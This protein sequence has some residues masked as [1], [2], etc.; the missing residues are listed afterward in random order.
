M[1]IG[2]GGGDRLAWLAAAGRNSRRCGRCCSLVVLSHYSQQLREKALTMKSSIRGAILGTAGVA[3][4]G[5]AGCSD[6]NVK[7]AGEDFTNTQAAPPAADAKA[8]TK[9]DL[10]KR[11]SGAKGGYPGAMKG[12]SSPAGKEKN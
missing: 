3:L 12:L 10:A 6:E 4:L 2:G 5:L 1:R 11:Y 8:P 9:A 7:N